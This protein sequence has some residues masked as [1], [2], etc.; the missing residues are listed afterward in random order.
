MDNERRSNA[1]RNDE[2]ICLH[3]GD[4]AVLKTFM[5]DT[6]KFQEMIRNIFVQNLVQIVISIGMVGGFVWMIFKKG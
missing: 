6:K 4:I 1:R 2:H 5:E 3:E